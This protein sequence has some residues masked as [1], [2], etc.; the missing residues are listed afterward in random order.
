VGRHI[1]AAAGLSTPCVLHWK[2]GQ[3]EVID[4][5]A[6]PAWSVFWPCAAIGHETAPSGSC[7]ALVF[8]HG[9]VAI[10]VP[11]PL[12]ASFR[13]E[14]SHSPSTTASGFIILNGTCLPI[15]IGQVPGPFSLLHPVAPLGVLLFGRRALP[16]RW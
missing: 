9:N 13:T 8:R 1:A 2:Y 4:A 16:A 5:R 3:L 11:L 15:T 12:L 10:G 7:Q 6:T 14:A